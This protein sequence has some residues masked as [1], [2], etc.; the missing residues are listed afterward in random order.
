MFRVN[1]EMPATMQ[2]KSAIA[3]LVSVTTDGDLTHRPQT[4]VHMFER[5]SDANGRD[6]R[7]MT[8]YSHSNTTTDRPPLPIPPHP[9]NRAC[10]NRRVMPTFRP[11]SRNSRA[12][13]RGARLRARPHPRRAAPPLLIVRLFLRSSGH[14]P[15]R[16]RAPIMIPSGTVLLI[17]GIPAQGAHCP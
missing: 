4:V 15:L 9:E 1:D 2:R 3:T 7:S 12:A 16:P 10:A 13:R 14:L 5:F 6:F 8:D 11:E 17:N